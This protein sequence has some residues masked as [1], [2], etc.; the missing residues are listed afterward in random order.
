M[1]TRT[2]NKEQLN[3]YGNS[4]NDERTFRRFR[5]N[6]I[7][8]KTVFL[9]NIRTWR[10]LFQGF[11]KIRGVTFVTSPDFLLSLYSDYDFEEVELLVGASLMDGYKKDLVGKEAAIESLYSRVCDGSLKLHGSKIN[12]HTKMYILTNKEKTRVITGSP[13]LSYTAAGSKQREYAWYVDIPHGDINGHNFLEQIEV[14]FQR[15]MEEAEPQLFMQDLQNLRKNS[16]NEAIEDYKLWSTSENLDGSNAMRTIIKEVQNVA[17]AEDEETEEIFTI[18]IPNSVKK[19]DQKYL[20]S[21]YGAKIQN[22]K[23]I[24]NRSLVLHEK[25]NH[26]M[27]N[28]RINPADGEVTIALGGG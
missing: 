26:G 20:S 23:A 1:E 14:D 7:F 13:N 28:M 11:P 12:I 18:T 2:D 5:S 19:S 4:T 6:T 10:N 25:T 21:N 17:F 24:F 9:K 8:P 16:Q 22:G 27:P 3:L 15:H